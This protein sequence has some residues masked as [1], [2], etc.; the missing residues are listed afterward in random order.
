M[1]IGSIFLLLG[2][3]ILVVLYI[4]RPFL[5]RRALLVTKDEQT[6]SALLAEKERL[7]SALQELDFDYTLGKIPPTDYPEQRQ[8]L[9]T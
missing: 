8:L 6:L 7:L 1:D 4:T 3:F 9:L 5:L 2:L